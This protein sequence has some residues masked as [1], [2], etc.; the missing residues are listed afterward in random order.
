MDPFTATIGLGG[1]ALQAFGAFESF[2]GA[3][4]KNEAQMQIARLEQQAEVQRKNA[5]EIAGRRAQL[6]SM[7]EYQQAT[8]LAT[9]RATNQGAQFSTGLQGGRA[10]ISGYTNSN[11]LNIGQNLEIGRNMFAINSQISQQKLISGEAE[12][13][14]A[15]GQGFGQLGKSL[16]GALPEIKN[17]AGFMYP[18]PSGY[19]P[20]MT[21]ANSYAGWA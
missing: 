2:G 14:M 11:L 12:T 6:Q 16:T 20:S 18:K 9:S 13:Q 19:S 4:K 21:G 7:R 5:M 1:L 15:W 8:A 17:L 3:N 10:Q